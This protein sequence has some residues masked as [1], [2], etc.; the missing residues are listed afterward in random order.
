MLAPCLR[1]RSEQQCINPP[2]L[3]SLQ[4][5]SYGIVPRQDTLGLLLAEE[6]GAGMGEDL[7]SQQGPLRRPVPTAQPSLPTPSTAAVVGGGI[8]SSCY[9]ICTVDDCTDVS[10]ADSSNLSQWEEVRCL[11]DVEA[12]YRFHV[13]QHQPYQH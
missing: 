7:A 3:P 12:M 10:G 11:M 4:M 9:G 2:L 5:A 1:R 8:V 6:L 13:K